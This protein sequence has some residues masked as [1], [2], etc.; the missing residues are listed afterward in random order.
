M[1]GRWEHIDKTFM[2]D[3]DI[4]FLCET[5]CDV[6]SFASK[7]GFSVYGDPTFPLFQRHDGLSVYVKECYT[8]FINDLRFSI[9]MMLVTMA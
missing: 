9:I 3:T 5:H 6:A 8:H 7:N 4:V 2:E 1:N